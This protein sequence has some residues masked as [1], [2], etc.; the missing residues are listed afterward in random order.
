MSSRVLSFLRYSFLYEGSFPVLT[1]V[2]ISPRV[3]KE[4]GF[5]PP[6]NE[7]DAPPPYCPQKTTGCVVSARTRLS[8]GFFLS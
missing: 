3:F 6:Q 7:G 5:M 1:Y 8:E 2:E 4:F